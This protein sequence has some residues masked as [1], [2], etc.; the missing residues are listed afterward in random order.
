M[1][2]SFKCT[3]C[4][5]QESQAPPGHGRSIAVTRTLLGI[6]SAS[7]SKAADLSPSS[8]S[9]LECG[10]RAPAKKEIGRLIGILATLTDH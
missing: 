1:T 6:S 9:R 4:P 10:R 5:P 3:H 8:L 2:S 7:L